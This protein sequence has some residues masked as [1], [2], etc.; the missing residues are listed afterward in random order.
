MY[1]F[2]YKINWNDSYIQGI[3]REFDHCDV[4]KIIKIIEPCFSKKL[5]RLKSTNDSHFHKFFRDVISIYMPSPK[6]TLYVLGHNIWFWFWVYSYYIILLYSWNSQFKI[7]SVFVIHLDV[8][9]HHWIKDVINREIH[10]LNPKEKY[11]FGCF[12][13]QKFIKSDSPWNQE[14]KLSYRKKNLT[15]IL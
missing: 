2:V 5:T 6:F 14:R 7:S 1:S 4:L 15:L 3:S 9:N 10:F 11:S 13:K 12:L 8:R